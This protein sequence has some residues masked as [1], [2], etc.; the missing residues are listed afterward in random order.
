MKFI[1]WLLLFT[2]ACACAT[3]YEPW[4]TPPF[5]F[6][7]RMGYRYEHSNS[8]QSPL[9]SFTKPTRDSSVHLALAVTPWPNWHVEAELFLTHT[10]DIDFA[11]EAA[12]LTVRYAW[13]DDIAGDCLS[14]VTGATFSFPPESFLH[15]FSFPYHGHA[16]AEFHATCGKEWSH[17]PEWHA[18]LWGLAGYGVAEK[19][20]P[21]IHGIGVAEYHLA[22][23]AL[24]GVFTEALYG[25]GNTDIV[26]YVPFTGYASIGHQSIDLG[27]YL[28]YEIR[29]WGTLKVV[30]WY[31]VYAHNYTENNWG[32]SLTFLVPFSVI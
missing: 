23:C 7:G 30:G 21:W 8:V 17:G 29:C 20:S 26:P 10:S 25:F 12:W 19:G 3:E 11:Y 16:N 14:F 28:D 2:P 27:G 6:Q 1:N 32:T 31:R 5:E 4:F 18:R 24:L 15:E 22:P 13:L 9:G